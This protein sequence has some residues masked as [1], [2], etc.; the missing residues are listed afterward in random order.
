MAIA[1]LV[2]QNKAA[3]ARGWLERTVQTYP[4]EAA[5]FFGKDSGRFSNPVGQRLADG[6]AEL[7]DALIEGHDA[8]RQCRA[9]D[10]VIELRA[11]QDFS[12]AQ[13]VSFVF[14]LKDVLRQTLQEELAQPGMRAEL[15]EFETRVDQL[16]LFAFDIYTRHRQRTYEIRVEEIKRQVGGLMRRSG[17]FSD[18]GDA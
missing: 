16:I 8:E 5:A 4:A 13:A 14:G 6:I 7:L 2:K 1:Q 3:I 12:P 17:M 9:L 10:P 18:D 15:M 11:I